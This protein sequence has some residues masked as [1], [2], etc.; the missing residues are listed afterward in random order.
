MAKQA[1]NIFTKQELDD[2]WENKPAGYFASEYKKQKNKKLF[3]VTTEMHI[4]QVVDSITS[5]VWA[6]S[7]KDAQDQVHYGNYQ[8]LRSRNKEKYPDAWDSR[9]SYTTRVKNG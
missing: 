5:E 2:I 6:K 9:V 3:I 8:T 4:P 1:K 7:G